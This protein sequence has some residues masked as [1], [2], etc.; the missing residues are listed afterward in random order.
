MYLFIYFFNA[1]V[2]K[3]TIRM[4]FVGTF[5][6]GKSKA[7]H[8]FRLLHLSTWWRWIAELRQTYPSL[9][10]VFNVYHGKGIF[11]FFLLLRT[12]MC[13]YIGVLNHVRVHEQY[14]TQ[15]FLNSK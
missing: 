13:E 2:S 12:N 9:S 4:M 6:P 15:G 10:T 14:T 3:N 11:H 5:L 7:C 8:L 1:K